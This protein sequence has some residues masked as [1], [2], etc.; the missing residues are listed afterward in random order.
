MVDEAG[1]RLHNETLHH[2]SFPQLFM[3]AYEIADDN[4]T[5]LLTSEQTLQKATV[6]ETAER[7]VHVAVCNQCC[8]ILLN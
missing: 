5:D 2:Q 1:T 7:G 4:I 3:Q 6:M 8:F